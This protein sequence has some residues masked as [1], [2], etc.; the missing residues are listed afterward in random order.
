M[1]LNKPQSERLQNFPNVNSLLKISLGLILFTIL[2]S[3]FVYAETIPVMLMVI[4]L[5]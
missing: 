4:P 3:A 5:M 2:S 1:G